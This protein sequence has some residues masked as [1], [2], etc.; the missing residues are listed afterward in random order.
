MLTHLLQDLRYGLRMLRAKPGFTIA[1]VLTLALG[2]GAN[3]AIFSVINGMLLRPLP[4]TDSERLV[5][6]YNTYPKM[7]LEIAGTSIPDY[8]DRRENAAALQDIAIYHGQSFNLADQGAPQRLIGYVATPSLFSTLKVEARIGRVFGAEAGE[9]GQDHVAVL[10]AA[11]WRNQ[12]NADSAV[13]GRD[14]RLNGES[15]RVVGVMDDAFAFPDRKAQLWVP[16]AFTP[17]QKSDDERGHEF[18]ESIGRL[19]PG[20]TLAE[21]DAQLDAITRANVDRIA[22]SGTKDGLGFKKFMDSSGFT[23][24]SKNLHKYLVGELAPVLLMLQAVVAFVLLI[25]CANVANLMLTRISARQ[26]ELSV[27]TALGAGRG[28]LA[29]QLLVESL[30]LALAGGLAG[31]VVAQWCLQ[32]IRLLGLD[33]AAHG[34]VVGLDGGVIAFTLVLALLTGILFGLFPAVALWRER[35][36]EV[37]KE[38]GRGSGGSRSARATRRVLVIVQMALAVTLL[39]GAGLLV[40][41][42]M[43]LQEASPGFDTQSV[44][45]VRVD[46]PNNRYKDDS[47]VAQFYERALAAVRALPGVSSAGIVSSMPFTNNNSQASYS[48]EGHELAAGESEPHGFVQVVDEDFF[49]TMQIPML[50]GRGFTSADSAEADKVVVIDDLLAKKYFGDASKALGHRI[51]RDDRQNGPWYTIIGVVGTVKRNKLYELTNKETY[52]Y[53]YRQQPDRS[54]TIAL[55]TAID[56]DT[57]VA[58]LRTALQRIDPEQPIYD[59][60]TMSERIRTSL[61]DRRT[62]MLL[63]GLFAALALA[64]SAIGIDGVLAFSVASRTGELGVRMSIGAQRGDIVRLVLVDGARLAGI[65][66]GIGL[67]GSLALSQLIKTQLF[68]VDT[69]DPP[70]LV[71]VIALLAVTAFVACWLPARR[72]SRVDPIEA[73]RHE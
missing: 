57:L 55:K 29:R 73:L 24:R 52:Y 1:A 66:L 23:G 58:P 22:A 18:S 65:G 50:Q 2:I 48:I 51:T 34:F 64:L 5:Y 67:V 28:R 10:S 43:H 68:G 26:K 8:L 61:D 14:I 41:S 42:F 54:S 16:F 11:L 3:S 39:A 49:K 15:Y 21:L 47:A 46:L 32:L 36:Y 38:G 6:V 37:L 33:D 70:T 13:V 72:A 7:N 4:Y 60:Q 30:L 69:I 27:R 56:P 20:A 19:K 45:S 44:L 59:V 25:A 17:K 9:T 40:R 31:L 35:A 62:P 12:F 63:L 53:Y 71:G